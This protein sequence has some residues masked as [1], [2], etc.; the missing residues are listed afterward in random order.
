MTS[1]PDSSLQL[2]PGAVSD[3]IDLLLEVYEETG[4]TRYLDRADYFG[5]QAAA[6]FFDPDSP[7][8]MATDDHGHYESITGG[9]DLMLSLANLQQAI[10]EP[11]SMV[12]VGGVLAA[13]GLRRTR[14]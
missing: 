12:L 4:D 1:E 5:Q 8:P 2:Y 14:R 9:P 11:A 6:L 10:P 7:L 3:A 13:V